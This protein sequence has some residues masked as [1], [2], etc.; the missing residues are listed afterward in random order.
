MRPRRGSR[1]PARPRLQIAGP[2]VLVL[3]M[4][5]LLGLAGCSGDDEEPA[6]D[7]TPVQASPPPP[8]A[9]AAPK[10]LDG[11]CYRL[12]FA[13]ALAPTT[14]AVPVDCDGR[15]T[16]VTFSV[17]TL[18]TLLDGHLLAVDSDRVIAQVART[19]PDRLAD[20]VGG[21]R[22]DRGLSMLRAVWFTPTV[23]QSDAG[24]D[25]FRCDVIAVAGR[26]SLAPLT[27]KLVGA[28]SRPEGRQRW[29]MCG[30]DD[31]DS[32]D[33]E[34]VLCSAPHSWRAIATL[35]FEPGDYPGLDVVRERGQAPCEDAG[36]A[37]ADDALNFQWSYEGPSREQWDAG[38]TY[39][40][41]WAPA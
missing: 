16:A 5:L 18:D 4:L 28:L 3:T 11:A 6:A 24:A 12:D 9:T 36:R 25:W 34:R 10:P 37:V 41:C 22:E 15:H 7:P 19:C 26:D 1:P 39:G 33:F 32:P 23:P 35:D 29:G 31:P 38:Q 8:T 17:G 13:D 20:F 2:G 27:G 40:R 30:T 21:S 14:D